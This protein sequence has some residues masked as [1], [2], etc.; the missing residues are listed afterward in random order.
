MG[1]YKGQPKLDVRGAAALVPIFSQRLARMPEQITLYTAKVSAVL[2]LAVTLC[3]WL[4]SDTIFICAAMSLRAS[5]KRKT[6]H[7]GFN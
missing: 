2:A 1:S 6:A 4:T 3:L 7:A 5:S